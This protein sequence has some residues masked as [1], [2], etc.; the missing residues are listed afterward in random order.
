MWVK[1]KFYSTLSF[2]LPIWL[3][4]LSTLRHKQAAHNCRGYCTSLFDFY[5]N[6]INV[7]VSHSRIWTL[8]FLRMWGHEVPIFISFLLHRWMEFNETFKESI[9]HISI[10]TSK[11]CTVDVLTNI[12]KM[13]SGSFG[14]E[15]FGQL[16]FRLKIYMFS[17]PSLSFFRKKYIMRF[18]FGFS[19]LL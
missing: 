12:V 2:P 3:I 18:R 19:I 9:L 4:V 7:R 13:I 5:P 1:L 16:K 17:V 15:H 10:D 8:F 11:V 6:W 14:L